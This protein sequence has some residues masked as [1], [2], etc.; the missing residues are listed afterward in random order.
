MYARHMFRDKVQGFFHDYYHVI[1]LS[2]YALLATFGGLH[3]LLF[4]GIV[5]GFLSVFSTNMSNYW[6]HMSGYRTYETNEDSK[7]TPW[8]LP[9][10]FGENWHNNHHHKPGSPF[11][12]ENGGRSIQ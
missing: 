12:G 9:I 5:P 1:I 11:P 6:N 2:Y 4:L 8:M 7:N 10:A 3:A